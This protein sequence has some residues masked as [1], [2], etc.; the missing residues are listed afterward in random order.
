MTGSP[1]SRKNL[2]AAQL[3]ARIPSGA[4]LA[5][6]RNIPI[7][8]GFWMRGVASWTVAPTARQRSTASRYCR[9]SANSAWIR[10]SPSSS[11]RRSWSSER[12]RT[13]SAAGPA[14]APGSPCPT[15]GAGVG[16]RRSPVGRASGFSTPAVSCGAMHARSSAATRSCRSWPSRLKGSIGDPVISAT[17]VRS[18]K[19]VPPSRPSWSRSDSADSGCF[20]ASR[21]GSTEATSQVAPWA[22]RAVTRTGSPTA[23]VT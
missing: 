10:R 19:G 18:S 6:S 1:A 15:R 9:M 17:S 23:A 21:A 12:T 4:C 7:S 22:V 2:T 5:S 16:A 3:R 8:S 13:W 14:P 11:T 20:V